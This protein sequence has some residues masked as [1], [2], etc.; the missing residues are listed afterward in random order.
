MQADRLP[1]RHERHQ[2]LSRLAHALRQRVVQGVAVRLN[3]RAPGS[4][5][6]WLRRTCRP[7]R[8]PRL[9]RSASSARQALMFEQ[10]PQFLERI[11]RVVDARIDRCARPSTLE[12]GRHRPD[13]EQAGRL[14][15]AGVA[16]GGLSGVRAQSISRSAI[17]P[18]PCLVGA[19]HVLQRHL[20]WRAYCPGPRNLRPVTWPGVATQVRRDQFACRRCDR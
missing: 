10:P 17:V 9:G 7:W 12:P 16:A 5:A 20:R 14:H 8:A 4:R 18:V 2:R 15:A 1:Q 3:L 6:Q 11:D 19:R 13:D